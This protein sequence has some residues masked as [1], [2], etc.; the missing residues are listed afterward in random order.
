MV[1]GAVVKAISYADACATTA[2]ISDKLL[3][4][5]L[6]LDPAE[7]HAR[8]RMTVD[9]AVTSFYESGGPPPDAV[10]PPPRNLVTYDDI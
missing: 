1:A 8:L 6:P 7:R 5:A 9:A 10:P 2:S 4:D 3:T